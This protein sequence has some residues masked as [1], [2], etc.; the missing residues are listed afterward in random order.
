M[1]IVRNIETI[2]VLGAKFKGVK[3]LVK[4]SHVNDPFNIRFPE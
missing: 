2:E 1:G 3:E 4:Y